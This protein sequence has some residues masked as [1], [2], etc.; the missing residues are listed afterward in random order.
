MFLTGQTFKHK[1]RWQRKTVLFKAWE[2]A[3]RK[4]TQSPSSASREESFLLLKNYCMTLSDLCYT[5]HQAK[6]SEWSFFTWILVAWL[7]YRK[8]DEP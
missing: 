7:E 3:E 4:A 2:A 1:G 6:R 5:E 8:Y